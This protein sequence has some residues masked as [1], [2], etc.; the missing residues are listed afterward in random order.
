MAQVMK[1]LTI[2]EASA[3]AGKHLGRNV[4]PSNIAYL[5]QYGRVKK[6]D[7]NGKTYVDVDDLLKYYNSYFGRREI[8][9]KRRLGEDLNWN[10]SFDNLKE[11]ERTKHVH[12]LHPYKGK[13]I[14]QLVEYFIDNHIDAFKREVYFQKGDIIL[15]PFC[16]SGTTLV[17]AN[18]LGIH[19]IGIDISRFNALISNAKI[20]KYNLANLYNE[21]RK[22][23]IALRQHIS[24]SNAVEFEHELREALASYNY[25]YF[26]SPDFKYRVRREEINEEEYGLEKE[27]EFR[28]IFDSL[29]DKYNIRL[30]Q[31]KNDTFLDRWY[32]ANVRH[33]IDYIHSLIKQIE[34]QNIKNVLMVILSRTIRSCRATTHFDLATLKE[35][36]YSTYY[37]HKHGKICKPLFSI[38]SW[39]VRYCG[40]TIGRLAKFDRLRTET[41]QVC[42]TGDARTL[43]IFEELEKESS[44]LAGLVKSKRIKGIFSSPPY[45]GLIDYHDQHAYAYELFK[46]ERNDQLE[47]GALFNGQGTK[48][49]ESYINSISEVLNNC[50]RFL[51]DDFDIFLV[52]N[53]K[54][55]LY[56]KIAEKAKMQILNRH[57]RPVLNRTERDK[58]AYSETIFHLRKR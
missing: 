14:P 48:A 43:N 52:A 38:V 13:F 36:V 55:E 1:L 4:T 11:Y 33:E 32:I 41:G 42:L 45:V 58:G 50:K 46:L 27:N 25:K 49:R 53:D 51:V 17:Q 3:W 9:W 56:S 20:N 35:P 37:C 30:K 47:I 54:Y 40:D 26:P 24:N 22:I 29:V 28:P 5:I 31:D 34:D 21:A 2:N 18:E 19:A 12:R 57:K 8:D 6:F 15:D 23:T 7:G 44:F 39:W 16:G 10:L